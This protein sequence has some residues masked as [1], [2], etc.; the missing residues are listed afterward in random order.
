MLF[1]FKGLRAW[2]CSSLEP[3]ILLSPQEL[4]LQLI[5]GKTNRSGSPDINVEAHFKKKKKG[6]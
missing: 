5:G 6:A 2:R 1:G 4:S 3:R